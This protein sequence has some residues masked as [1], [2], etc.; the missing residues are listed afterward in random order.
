MGALQSAGDL[1]GG[2]LLPQ[3]D[4]FLELSVIVVRV[5]VEKPLPQFFEF[6][7]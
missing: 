7:G 5:G 3:R 2:V 4:D 6:S 1:G